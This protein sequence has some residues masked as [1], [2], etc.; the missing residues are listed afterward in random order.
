MPGAEPA[1]GCGATPVFKGQ[2]MALQS[3]R[4][5]VARATLAVTASWFT[6]ILDEQPT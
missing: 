3:I 4:R 5:E 6:N 1:L 2:E